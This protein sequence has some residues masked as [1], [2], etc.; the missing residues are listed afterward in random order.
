LCERGSWRLL[1]WAREEMWGCLVRWGSRHVVGLF[2][3]FERAVAIA[4]D[5]S[6]TW[7]G[8]AAARA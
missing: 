3:G 2:R 8:A 7:D 6:V 5:L 1:G 4:R